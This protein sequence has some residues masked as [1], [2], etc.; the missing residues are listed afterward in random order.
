[1]KINADLGEG[2]PP[3]RTR[4]LLRIV[5]LANIACGGHVG[6]LASMERTVRW[7]RAENVSIGAHPGV[8]GNFGRG[9]GVALSPAEFALLLTQQVGG[10]ATVCVAA[11]ATLHHVKLHGALYHA[12]ENSPRLAEIYVKTLRRLFPGV[13]VVAFAGGGVQAAARKARV[14]ALAEVFAERGYRAD[15]TLVP[16]GQAG[17]LIVNP[18]DVAK[19]VPDLRGDTICVHADSPNAVRIARAVRAVLG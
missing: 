3:A 19:R 9:V 2:E 7:A 17:S 5:D 18:R 8:E 13:S 12:V 16:R 15:G 4:A 1:M 14:P 10:F 6:D 11:G